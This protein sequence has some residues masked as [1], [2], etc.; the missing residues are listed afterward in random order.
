MNRHWRLGMRVLFGC[1]AVFGVLTAEAVPVF[2]VTEPWVRVAPDG[3]SAE[4]FMELRSSDGAAIVAVKSEVVAGITMRP[5]GAGRATV[6]K[7]ALP[8]GETVLLAP[9]AQR[10]AIAKLGKPLKPG[11]RL[12]FVLVVEGA[13]GGMREIP[14]NAE[15]RRRSPTDDH[16]L[17]H[18]HSRVGD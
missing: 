7:I 11:D 15:V 14:V 17:P 13:D 16:R 5:A 2:V 6:A 9:G 18:R 4:A 10:L 1:A 12:P 8:P 3:R